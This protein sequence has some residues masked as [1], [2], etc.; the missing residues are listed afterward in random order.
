MIDTLVKLRSKVALYGLWFGGIL[1]LLAAIVI[2]V[3]V[4]LRRFLTISIG[5]ADELAQFALAIGSTWAFAGALV[6]RCHIRVDSAYHFFPKAIQRTADFVSLILFLVFFSLIAWHAKDMISQS[7]ISD[8]I[9]RSS[10][11]IPMVIPQGIWLLGLLSFLF[12]IVITLL[13]G[14][15]F[16]ISGNIDEVKKLAGVKSIDEE[17]IEE[18]CL[19]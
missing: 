6:D 15:H 1:I 3:D 4:I 13:A 17:V 12:S 16:W 11:Q 2:G 18:T 7:W 9:S 19:T 5:G 14:I 10:L 8:T